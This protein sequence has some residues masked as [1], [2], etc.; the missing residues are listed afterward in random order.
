MIHN[1]Y[2]ENPLS[3]PH[4]SGGDSGRAAHL[5]EIHRSVYKR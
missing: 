5:A 1:R 3:Q 2:T 4:V